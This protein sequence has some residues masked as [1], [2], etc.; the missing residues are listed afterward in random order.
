MYAIKYGVYRYTT[1]VTA[2]PKIQ[3][4]GWCGNINS[5]DQLRHTRSVAYSAE[6]VL[7]NKHPISGGGAYLDCL[8]LPTCATPASWLY[9]RRRCRRCSVFV[10]R[11]ICGVILDAYWTIRR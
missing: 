7:L 8:L 6:L 5:V 10:R 1:P 4:P 9:F 2:A 3:P 11:K